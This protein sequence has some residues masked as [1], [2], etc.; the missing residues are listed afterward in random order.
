MGPTR[1]KERFFGPWPPAAGGGLSC[2]GVGILLRTQG[3]AAKWP[4]ILFVMPAIIGKVLV[5]RLHRGLMGGGQELECG[6]AGHH[7]SGAAAAA[8]AAVTD[9]W[10]ELTD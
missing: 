6:L 8:A 2:E 7:A 4:L 1:S 3:L 9:Q 5:E 10:D